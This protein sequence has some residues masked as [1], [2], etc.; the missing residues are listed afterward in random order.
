[1]S[2]EPPASVPPS[3]IDHYRLERRL[4]LGG[5]AEIFLAVDERSG[6]RVAL[7]KILPHVASDADFRE[8]FFHEIRIQIAL[9]HPNIVEL[10]DCSPDPAHAYIVMEYV[11]GGELYALKQATGRLPWEIALHAVNQALRGLSAAHRK[12]VIHR[13]VK[14]QNVMYTREGEVKIGDFGISHAAHLTRLTVT[15]TVVGT[16]AHM[17]PEQARGEELDPRTDLFSAG[18]VLYEL[19]AG[20][21]PFTAD[22]IA[23]TLHRVVEVEPEVPSLL[24]PTIPPS[25]DGFLRKLHA[26]DRRLRFASA[27][28]A[29][30]AV[31]DLFAREKVT[32]APAAFREFLADPA[33]F[34]TARNRR[35]ASESATAAERLLADRS[36]APE[37]ALWA[38]YR[39]VACAPDDAAAQTL[40]R[41]AAERA[42]QRERPVENPKIRELEQALRKDPDN[43]ALLLQLAKLYRLEKDFINLMRFMRK[44]REVAP[45]DPYTQGQIAALV[46]TPAAAPAVL[47]PSAAAAGRPYATIAVPSAGKAHSSPWALVATAVVVLLLVVGGVVLS[48]RADK[49]FAIP[50]PARRAASQAPPAPAERRSDAALEAVLARGAIAEKQTGAAAAA[51]VYREALERGFAPDGREAL[52][53]ALAEVLPRAGDVDGALAAFDQIASLGTPAR[54][55]ALL[56]SADLLAMQKREPA[57]RQIWEALSSADGPE[58]WK[59]KLRLGMDADREHDAVRALSLYEEVIARAPDGPEVTAA[60][61]GAGALYRDERR[62][63]AARQMFE[64]VLR[65]APPESAEAASAKSGLASLEGK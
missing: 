48:R 18:T 31:A 61:L 46:S 25:V 38:A 57:A 56:A 52:L 50:D 13:D 58:R 8:R 41:T 15:G 5:M 27:D 34:V 43:P 22:S 7:K 42:G 23:A 3:R 47:R 65:R 12:G 21:N 60:R 4:G 17:S 24:D 36:A 26:K 14:P 9:K 16:P 1:M 63:G 20:H 40:L 6:R 45:A 29:C 11:D 39:T 19:L 33:G 62:W 37:E 51:A 54:G 28:A 53:F 44:L 59:A 55:R 10:L 32:G 49:N 30:E 64:E 2:L 35:L